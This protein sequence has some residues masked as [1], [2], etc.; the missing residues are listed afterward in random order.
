MILTADYHTH[1]KYSDGRDS[2]LHNAL[3]AKELG[4]R[5]I[6]ITEH[7]FSHVVLGLKRKKA[8][9]YFADIEN[10]RKE[11]GMNI[12]VGIE[13]NILGREGTCDLTE[14]DYEKFDL[15]LAGVHILVHYESSHDRKNGFKGLFK[16]NF[17]AKPPERLV[18]EQT[19][20]YIHAIERNPIDVLTHINYQCFCDSVEVAKCCADYGTYIEIS[21]KKP[22]FSDEELFKIAET[23]VRFIVNSD[24]HSPKRI[25]DVKIAMEQIQRVNIPLDRV[26]NIDGRLPKFRF[27][28]YKERNL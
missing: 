12:L 22:H 20:G 24:A 23:G 11:T 27:K 21:G 7:G 17:H 9:K 15:Y 6:A 3:R 5:E 18:K 4:L 2:V 8:D 16:Y 1:T 13:S 10:A 19:L 26:D 28:E 25:G 14:R